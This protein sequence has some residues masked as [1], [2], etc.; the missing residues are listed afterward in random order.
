MR[1]NHSAKKHYQ[2]NIAKYWAQVDIYCGI[3][4][5]ETQDNF[6][7]LKHAWETTIDITGKNEQLSHSSFKFK[8]INNG[9]NYT[10]I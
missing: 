1:H 8:K 2:C 4:K 3:P 7:I 9:C 5:K 10:S 6:L